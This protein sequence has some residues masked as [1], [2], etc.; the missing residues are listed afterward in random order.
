MYV[1]RGIWGGLKELRGG[2]VGC[3]GEFG[4]DRGA[5]ILGFGGAGGVGQIDRFTTA[6]L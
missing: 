4:L 5:L 6:R 1:M 2:R 3:G